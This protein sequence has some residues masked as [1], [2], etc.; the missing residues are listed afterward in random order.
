MASNGQ[1]VVPRDGK[2]AV[3]KTGSVK[4]TK[5]FKTQ[6]EAITEGRRLAKKQETELYIHGR[7]GLIRARE[8]YGNDPYPPKG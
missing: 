2:W 8:S 7:D 3:R 4:L 1:H 6:K 5:K